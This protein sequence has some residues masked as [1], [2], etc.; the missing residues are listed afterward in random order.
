MLKNAKPG[1]SV[2][3]IT[4]SFENP[5]WQALVGSALERDPQFLRKIRLFGED[6]SLKALA[7]LAGGENAAETRQI[8]ENA[9][10]ALTTVTGPSREAALS[11]ANL[12]K[13][14][15]EYESTA[16]K[17][18]AEAADEVQKVRDLINAGDLAQASARLDLIKRGL[19][20][21]FKIGR[22]HV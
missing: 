2:A 4:A 5:T 18:T 1:Q 10:T 6:E 14:V 3:E 11:R 9:K 13:A 19:P 21:G 8:L 22:A 20:V 12:G 17:L 7:K 16:G 15:A